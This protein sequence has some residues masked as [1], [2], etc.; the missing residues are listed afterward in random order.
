MLFINVETLLLRTDAGITALPSLRV[1][2]MSTVLTLPGAP[3][4]VAPGKTVTMWFC[5]P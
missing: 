5:E 4:S 1:P 2:I 3:F